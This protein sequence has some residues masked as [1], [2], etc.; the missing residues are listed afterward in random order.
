[1]KWFGRKYFGEN[2]SKGSRFI[3]GLFFISTIFCT[4]HFGEY[5]FRLGECGFWYRGCSNNAPSLREFMAEGHA[6][7]GSTRHPHSNSPKSAKESK[8]AKRERKQ[9]QEKKRRK[10]HKQLG[11]QKK[12]LLSYQNKYYDMT[13]IGLQQLEHCEQAL[14][15]N[16][17][18]RFMVYKDRVHAIIRTMKNK[19]KIVDR[20]NRLGNFIQHNIYQES[21]H[22]L[23]QQDG[24]AH[25]IP[26]KNIVNRSASSAMMCATNKTY[27]PGF[28]LLDLANRA[29]VVAKD[30]SK[31]VAFFVKKAMEGVG[32]GGQDIMDFIRNPQNLKH[33][34]DNFSTH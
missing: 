7:L 20:N 17:E 8:A 15:N 33:K 12:T 29:C 5:R 32:L 13:V 28:A 1:M 24:P 18:D 23:N 10:Q 19:G 14:H 34:I 27:K 2:G 22:F 3:V 9:K 31:G 4:A 30:F 6:S 16:Q 26:L 11:R 21:L 25:S